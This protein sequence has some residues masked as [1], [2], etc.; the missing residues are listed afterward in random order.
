MERW[1]IRPK[2]VEG[3]KTMYCEKCKRIFEEEKSPVC[4]H[5]QVRNPEP[6]DLCFLTEQDYV[7]SGILEDVLKQDGIPYLRKD[8]MGAGMAIKVGPML[9]RGRFYV[10]YEKLTD[11]R[12]VVDE[13]FT[14]IR[15]EA[16]QPADQE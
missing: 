11:A 12:V 5:S 1:S 15:D 3:G 8:V 13:L 10:M 2:G 9:D 7:S 4:M 6:G 14:G 16:G